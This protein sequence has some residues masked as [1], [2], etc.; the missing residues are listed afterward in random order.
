MEE[1]LLAGHR[2]FI[3]KVHEAQPRAGRRYSYMD[4]FFLFE[5][6]GTFYKVVENGSKW[7]TYRDILQNSI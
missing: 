6:N 2:G 5:D 1:V 4:Y 7:F 3:W